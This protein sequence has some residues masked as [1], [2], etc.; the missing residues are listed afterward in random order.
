[1]S[2]AR[3]LN[4]SC[5]E[6]VVWHRTQGEGGMW[7]RLD[8]SALLSEQSIAVGLWAYGSTDL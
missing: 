4:L 6:V 3:W 5:G 1:M 8:N 2:S 7:M